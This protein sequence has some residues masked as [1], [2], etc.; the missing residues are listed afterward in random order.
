MYC[1]RVSVKYYGGLYYI[2]VVQTVRNVH[3]SPVMRSTYV[4]RDRRVVKTMR[5]VTV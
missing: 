2:N 4:T 3:A 1:N 5:Y